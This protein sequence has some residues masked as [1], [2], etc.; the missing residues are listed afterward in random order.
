MI[1]TFIERNKKILGTLVLAVLL[2]SSL[3]IASNS[4]AALNTKPINKSSYYWKNFTLTDF[5]GRL[6]KAADQGITTLY[7]NIEFFLNPW[8]DQNKT[9]KQISDMVIMAKS[10][11]ISIH[12]MMGNTTWSD[13]FTDEII[14]RSFAFIQ[15]YNNAYPLSL[16]EGLHLNV[17]FY[18]KAGFTNSRGYT[19]ANFI[20][21]SDNIAA[22]VKKYQLLVPQFSLSSTIP[23]FADYNRY[24]PNVEYEGVTTS[25]F[26][27]V[28]RTF[29]NLPNSNLVIMAYRSF[30]LG[31]DSI[32]DITKT[33]FEITKKRFSKLKIIIAIETIDL[34]DKQVSFYGKS[35][36]DIDQELVKVHHYMVNNNA[37]NGIA[38]HILDSYIDLK[39]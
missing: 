10:Y 27:H 19:T 31:E 11:G 24:I 13:P 12:A 16:I 34:K 28:A 25:L 7:V 26:E 29:N 23:H 6:S 38:V 4:N 20:R 14:Y 30:A 2:L 35:R 36:R 1:I 39:D 21:F 32:T 9:F 37:Y 22:E 18:N 33:E 3:M 5:K 17:E 15:K 8:L